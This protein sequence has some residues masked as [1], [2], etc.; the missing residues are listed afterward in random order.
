[1]SNSAQSASSHTHTLL[2]F[3][4][5]LL[6][7]EEADGVQGHAMKTLDLLASSAV[8][9]L[10]I[11]GNGFADYAVARDRGVR[12]DRAFNE[13]ENVAREDAR[14]ARIKAKLSLTPDQE[15]EWPVLATALHD[16]ATARAD[17]AIASRIDRGK[18]KESGGII[19]Y[20]NDRARLLGNRS[21]DLTKLAEAAQPLNAS[22]NEQ[23]KRRFAGELIRRSGGRNSE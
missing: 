12:I 18:R 19:E 16:I 11:V 20:L 7:S 3:E 22:L 10:I 23:Q 9:A 21:S 5:P 2:R 6:L 4:A 1:V 15:K 13:R 17:R 14:T 8:A